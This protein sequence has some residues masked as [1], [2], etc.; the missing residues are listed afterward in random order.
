METD[1]VKKMT[2][3]FK[4]IKFPKAGKVLTIFLFKMH[5]ISTSII[6]CCEVKDYYSACVLFRSLLE[7]YFKHLYIYTRTLKENS[8]SVSEEY[9]GKLKGYEDFTYLK[10]MQ[11]LSKKL[12]KE[13]TSF[14]LEDK[15]NEELCKVGRK[16]EIK[17]I[18]SYLNEGIDNKDIKSTFTD[19]FTEYCKKYYNLS[20]FVHGGPFAEEYMNMYS[21]DE[22]GM[23]KDL[24]YFLRESK[25]LLNYVKE[26][27]YLF[28]NITKTST[29]EDIKK[30]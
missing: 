3:D 5:Y 21:K 25:S 9:Y 13:K 15:D 18:L 6:R 16:F 8:D 27:T 10:S 7:H 20:S 22:K 17:T 4:N 19:F 2:E 23:D 29:L 24:E 30:P 28:F 12:T 1:Q 14:K 26:N 11:N